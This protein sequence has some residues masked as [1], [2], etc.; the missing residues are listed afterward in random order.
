MHREDLDVGEKIY[1]N[2]RSHIP[3][4][5]DIISYSFRNVSCEKIL[6]QQRRAYEHPVY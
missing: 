4:D 2:T 1:Q 6:F 5:N 3:E